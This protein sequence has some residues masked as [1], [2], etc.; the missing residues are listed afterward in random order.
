MRAE[1]CYNTVGRTMPGKEEFTMQ[2]EVKYI[3]LSRSHGK[4]IIYAELT[5][6]SAE[7]IIDAAWE[8]EFRPSNT[9]YRAPREFLEGFLEG[10]ARCMP[11]V[12]DPDLLGLPA[13]NIWLDGVTIAAVDKE[14]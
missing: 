2:G 5:A 9:L 12:R 7:D 4:M 10:I 11:Y 14:D 1:I 3:A 6:E 8:L 13:I